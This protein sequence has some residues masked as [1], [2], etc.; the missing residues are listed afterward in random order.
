MVVSFRAGSVVVFVPAVVF[1]PETFAEVVVAVVSRSGRRW[2]NLWW[3][4]SPGL[5]LFRRVCRQLSPGRGVREARDSG[6]PPSRP[7]ITA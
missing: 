4:L 7:R 1:R 5:G 2:L 6:L 3:Q